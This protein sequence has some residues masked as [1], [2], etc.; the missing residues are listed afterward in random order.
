MK[1]QQLYSRFKE[2][3]PGI[4]QG[5]FTCT[6]KKGK[7]KNSLKIRVDNKQAYIFTYNGEDNWSLER[8]PVKKF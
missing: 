1:E 7:E 2:K 3:C 4:L 8:I 5:N 6:F